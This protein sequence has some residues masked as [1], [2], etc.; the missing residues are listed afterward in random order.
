M[1]PEYDPVVGFARAAQTMAETQRI[2]AETTQRLEAT[3][4]LALR[5]LRGVVWL[6]GF[7]CVMI[8][9]AL[10]GLG[11]LI[12]LGVTQSAEHAAL[13]QALRTETQTLA[14]QTQALLET[15]R[16]SQP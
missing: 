4:H 3:Q 15:L 5:T 14:A 16:R 7:A 2:L 9:L 6:Q 1:D 8:G 12:W 11:S 10:V 13:T